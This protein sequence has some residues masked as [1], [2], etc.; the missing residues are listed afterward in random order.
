LFVVSY[1]KPAHT[2]VSRSFEANHRCGVATGNTHP[3][4]M[5]VC[6]GVHSSSMGRGLKG[7]STVSK[8]SV[9]LMMWSLCQIKQKTYYVSLL[10]SMLLELDCKNLFHLDQHLK[11]I[12]HGTPGSTAA[13]RATAFMTPMHIM[14]GASEDYTQLSTRCSGSF[15]L[16][17]GKHC[18]SL[19]KP[20][21][22]R[23]AFGR[24]VPSAIYPR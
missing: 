15:D 8:G 2:N 16:L 22:Q 21:V 10:N 6:F 12:S 17:L 18:S 19:H 23:L 14:I 5:R 1:Y 9:Y 11:P 20:N 24:D 3:E 4:I 7:K 13:D